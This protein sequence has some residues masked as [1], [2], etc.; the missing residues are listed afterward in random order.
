VPSYYEILGVPPDATQAEIKKSF[1]NLALQHHPDKNRNSEESK[2]KFMKIIE[3]Y[4]VLSDEQARK[5]YDSNILQRRATKTRWT[6]SA[7]FGTV[8]SYEEIKRRYKTG[9]VGGG[10]WDISDKASFGIWKATILLFACLVALLLYI[11][12]LS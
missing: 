3:A 4:E 6:P 8:Y 5:N 12:L 10:M 2:Q 7:D 1:R 11:T 9:T